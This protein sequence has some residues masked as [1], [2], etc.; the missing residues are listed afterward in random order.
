MALLQVL[1]QDRYAKQAKTIR[2]LLAPIIEAG[3][4][5]K[6]FDEA[7]EA[8][9]E[10]IVRLLGAGYP[11]EEVMS[12]FRTT[13]QTVAEAF[14]ANGGPTLVKRRMPEIFKFLLSKGWTIERMATEA[15]GGNAVPFLDC[16]RELGEY[17]AIRD[18]E[19]SAEGDS[20]A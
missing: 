10:A 13:E 18:Y 1:R 4:R 20:N 7:I 5:E 6:E 19:K 11:P 17:S 15:C 9:R 16:A 3:R 12:R 8:Q 2:R 14:M